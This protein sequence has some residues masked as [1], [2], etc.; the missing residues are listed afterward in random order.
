MAASGEQVYS[1]YNTS[2]SP[3]TFNLPATP[4]SGEIITVV[5]ANG[6]AATQMITV[7]GNGNNIWAYNG[8]ATSVGIASGGGS[9]RLSWDTIQ[10]NQ[11]G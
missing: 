10:W 6:N 2:G 11:I 9:I 4:V 7:Q 5:D 3:F 8:L 1:V